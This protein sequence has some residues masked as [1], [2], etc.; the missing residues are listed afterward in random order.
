MGFNTELRKEVNTLSKAAGGKVGSSM[1]S[2]LHSSLVKNDDTHQKYIKYKAKFVSTL[3]GADKMLYTNIC[4]I[5]KDHFNNSNPF[6]FVTTGAKLRSQRAKL[7]SHLNEYQKE[8]FT[9]VNR[10]AANILKDEATFTKTGRKLGKLAMT[11]FNT[12]FNKVK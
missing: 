12:K 5:E 9:K 6:K 8:L 1:G 11:E 4:D 2:K 3:S 7:S 10:L